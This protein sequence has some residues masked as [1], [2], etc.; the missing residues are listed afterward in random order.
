VARPYG[1]VARFQAAAANLLAGLAPAGNGAGQRM[2]ALPAQ[3][4][5]TVRAPAR[6]TRSSA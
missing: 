2:P 3:P 4:K 6:T 1:D 5:T